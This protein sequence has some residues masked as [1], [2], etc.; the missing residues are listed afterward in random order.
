M[1]DHPNPHPGGNHPYVP[2]EADR[3]FHAFQSPDVFWLGDPAYMAAWR[4]L[5]GDTSMT[6][7]AW[8]DPTEGSFPGY[9]N[10]QAGDGEMVLTVRGAPTGESGVDRTCGAPQQLRVPFEAWDQL[11]AD[12]QRVRAGGA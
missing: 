3:Q 9:V 7:A 5:T 6:E 12:A 8:T 1:Y 2:N 4:E 10:I 11:I